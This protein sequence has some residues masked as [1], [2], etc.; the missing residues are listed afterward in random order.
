MYQLL[1]RLYLLNK[2][3][4][5]ARIEVCGLMLDGN[6]SF[7]STTQ[8]E[9]TAADTVIQQETAVSDNYT[10]EKQNSNGETERHVL[11]EV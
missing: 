6:S 10:A 9:A 1:Y 4:T 7:G 8:R 5:G 2:P 3:G 11:R